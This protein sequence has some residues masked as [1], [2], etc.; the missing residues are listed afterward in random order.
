MKNKNRKMV[1]N[2]AMTTILPVGKINTSILC[3]A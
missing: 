3:Q 1:T 2:W